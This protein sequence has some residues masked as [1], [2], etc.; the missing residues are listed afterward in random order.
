MRILNGRSKIIQ[1]KLC[2]K[3][4]WHIIWIAYLK[5]HNTQ[6]LLLHPFTFTYLLCVSVAYSGCKKVTSH[7]SLYIWCMRSM[8]SINT[9][10]FHTYWKIMSSHQ[11]SKFHQKSKSCWRMFEHEYWNFKLSQKHHN[12][13]VM[14]QW[15]K[16]TIT[17]SHEL[18]CKH[19]Y[20]GVVAYM[21][22]IFTLT[23]S[24]I[25]SCWSF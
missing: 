14:W 21:P 20:D 16:N 12:T 23:V 8:I 25:F 2:R 9:R 18:L 7:T 13:E 17:P 5:L 22:F 11:N 4:L 1:R 10:L 3:T 15:P 24:L 19:R 6:V